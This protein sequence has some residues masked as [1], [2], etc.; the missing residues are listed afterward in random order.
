MLMLS[1]TSLMPLTFILPYFPLPFPLFTC[2][3]LSQTKGKVETTQDARSPQ[4]NLGLDN[5]SLCETDTHVEDEMPHA[6][7]KVVDKGETEEELDAAA[8]GVGHAG[9]GL[10]EALALNVPPEQGGDEVGGEV[11]VGGPGQGAAR[12][13]GP[14]RVAEPGLVELV[15]AEVGG[16]GA[17]EALLDE[18][19]V[20]LGGGVL[21]GGDG[22]R[23]AGSDTVS[24]F[25][26]ASPLIIASMWNDIGR[27]R[28][29]TDVPS[30]GRGNAGRQSKLGEVLGEEGAVRLG[31]A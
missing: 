11:E 1:F 7:D 8:D 24:S 14:G 13:S 16:D 21:D 18:N 29:G 25:L 19:V 3:N 28:L 22:A 6:V 10:G 12:D 27:G 5:L 17:V 20:A 15:D 4:R 9:K 30:L 26:E 23:R 2:S 31:R